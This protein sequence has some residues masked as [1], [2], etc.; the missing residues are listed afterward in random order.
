MFHIRRVRADRGSRGCCRITKLIPFSSASSPHPHPPHNQSSTKA[1]KE[2]PVK[3]KEPETYVYSPPRAGE[4]KGGAHARQSPFI[5]LFF[6]SS[7]SFFVDCLTA[8]FHRHSLCTDTSGPMAPSYNPK[9]VEDGWYAWWVKQV[10]EDM[11]AEKEAR[12]RESE[13]GRETEIDR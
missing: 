4:K 8:F 6:A 7:P 11:S 5:F 1:K 13:K 3:V 2:K 10:R 12:G 9:E